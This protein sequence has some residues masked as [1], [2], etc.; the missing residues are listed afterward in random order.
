MSKLRPVAV[1]ELAPDDRT[2]ANVALEDAMA[3]ASRRQVIKDIIVTHFLSGTTKKLKLFD[4]AKRAGITR[5]AL[6]RY[7]ADLKPYMAGKK[8]FTDL[9]DGT[10]DKARVE[11]QATINSVDARW[12]ARLEQLQVDQD[13]EVA[14]AIHSHITTLMNG[15]IAVFESN[16]LRK[17]L[18]KQTL[19]GAELKKTNAI[20][21]LKLARSS[22]RDA[23][24]ASPSSNN[25]VVYDV[26]IEQLCIQYQLTRS[27][28]AFDEGKEME[29]RAIREKF[30]R[31]AAT[32]NVHVVLFA[33]R[34]IS[35]FSHFADSYVGPGDETSLIIRLPL[36][37]RVEINN[38]IKHIPTNFKKSLYVPFM[39]LE[40]ERKA[41]RVFIYRQNPLPPQEIQAADGADNP[42]MTWSLDQVVFFKTAQEG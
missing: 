1:P 13:K 7:Y 32:P 15:D 2:P 3:G 40:A 35:R 27:L 41:Q 8:D 36:F 39:P 38:F 21:E 24:A 31:F 22:Q 20:L 26:P 18:E 10:Q 16:Q 4:V 5:Q 11:T 29:L 19:Y 34:Y 28:T 30:A 12:K 37:T 23:S 33:D 14:K 6:D 9:V 25:K 42:N 17:T